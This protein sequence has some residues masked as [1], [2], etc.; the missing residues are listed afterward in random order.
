[1]ATSYGALCTDFYVNQ[2]LALK[3]DLP[4]DRETILHLFDRVKK[5]V[6]NMNRFHRYHQFHHYLRYLLCHLTHHSHLI[7]LSRQ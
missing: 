2:K 5:T 6:P 1:M 4:S 3:M 7:H